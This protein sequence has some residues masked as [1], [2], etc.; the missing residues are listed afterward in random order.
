[1]IRAID[2]KFFTPA[3][4]AG[5]GVSRRIGNGKLDVPDEPEK[6]EEIANTLLTIT[7]PRAVIS[8]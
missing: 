3:R 6:A 4:S 2:F 1:M 7:K 8:R 5:D